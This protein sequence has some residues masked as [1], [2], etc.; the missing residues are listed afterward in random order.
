MEQ[1]AQL[2]CIFGAG[3]LMLLLE[4]LIFE[5]NVTS[6]THKASICFVYFSPYDNG[7]ALSLK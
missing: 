4:V 5:V 7:L 2:T 1:I 3:P 6:Y